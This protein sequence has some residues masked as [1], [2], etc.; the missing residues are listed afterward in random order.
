MTSPA[1]EHFA[2]IKE[3][4]FSKG[5]VIGEHNARIRGF[6]QKG[7]TNAGHH[8][9]LTTYYDPHKG[10]WGVDLRSFEWTSPV[11]PGLFDLR[12]VDSICR[13]LMEGFRLLWI[14]PVPGPNEGG[15]KIQLGRT[16]MS[17]EQRR[18]SFSILRAD[19]LSVYRL[20]WPKL[21][22]AI[23]NRLTHDP[24]L[25]L[26]GFTRGDASQAVALLKH[27]FPWEWVR[28]RYRDAATKP[29]KVGMWDSMEADQGFPAYLLAR[30]AIGCICKDPGWNFLLTLAESCKLLRTF[31]KG[32]LLI[33][34]IATEPGHIHQ[35]NFSAYLL[36]RHLLVEIEPSTGS[37][38]AKHDMA[39]R[40]ESILFDIEMK[41]LTSANP[42]RQ[43]AKEIAEK[44][45][46]LPSN[47]RRPVVFF[48]LLVESSF[49]VDSKARSN[50]LNW[51]TAEVFGHSTGISA[52]VVG[53]M[54]IDSAGGPVK[55][56]FDKFVINEEAKSR[57]DD[58]ALR[59]VFEPNWQKLV[60]PLM[61]IVFTFNLD[62][63][64][65]PAL[66]A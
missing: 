9:K 35:A 49:N 50:E 22:P 29:S 53:R 31:P 11:A 57:V 33:R 39:A 64:S 44:S 17:D 51:I 2:R 58:Q 8:F 24:E 18:E 1:T 52:A 54:F 30:T 56:G 23:E 60:Y 63:R 65:K 38:S 48:V 66:N 13:T 36:K 14:H 15:A 26:N 27:V 3:I 20:D 6:L 45:R 62:T 59:K 47:P 61:P 5:P 19:M 10:L 42:A 46:Q 55:W 28:R 4:R 40:V 37:G 21:W 16:F 43:V 34:R 25:W 12:N 7:S 41:A 32:D